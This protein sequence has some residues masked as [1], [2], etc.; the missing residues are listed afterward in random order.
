MES[1]RPSIRSTV[2]PCSMSG[3]LRQVSLEPAFVESFPTDLEEGRLYISIP[4]AT[5]A[6]KCCCGCGNQVVT[7]LTPTDWSLTYD[8]E[9]VSLSPSIGNWSF[10]CRSHYWIRRSQVVWARAWSAREIKTALEKDRELKE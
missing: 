3:R 1:G 7:P 6:H 9:S 10:E 4:Y 8:G 5:A 2:T